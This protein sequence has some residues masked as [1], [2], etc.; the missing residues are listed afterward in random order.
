MAVTNLSP[1]VFTDAV[2]HYIDFLNE[3]FKDKPLCVSDIRDK[4]GKQYVRMNLKL[5]YYF[6]PFAY[7]LL[8]FGGW[9]IMQRHHLLSLHHEYYNILFIPFAAWLFDIIEN[10]MALS[11][12]EKLTQSKS[13]LLFLASLIKWLLVFGYIIA[14]FNMDFNKH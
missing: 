10:K 7:L 14:L 12:L 8:F 5:D 13:R 1:Q 2:Q 6:M 4:F 9:Y 11:C 3:K